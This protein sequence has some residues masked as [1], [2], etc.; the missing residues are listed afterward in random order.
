M[1]MEELK[2]GQASPRQHHTEALT[3][4]M[5]E[6]IQA[7]QLRNQ[8]AIVEQTWLSYRAAVGALQA[9]RGALRE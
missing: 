9:L 5:L 2:D 1:K 6:Q 4:P 3:A 8:E 7:E